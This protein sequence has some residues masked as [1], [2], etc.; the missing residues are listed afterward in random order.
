[1]GRGA[2]RATVHGITMSWTRLKQ[3]GMQLQWQCFLFIVL[4]I[5]FVWLVVTDDYPDIAEFGI[6]Y[7][8]ISAFKIT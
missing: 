2:W 7:K 8:L 4:Q 6:Y 3:L 1:M 5:N